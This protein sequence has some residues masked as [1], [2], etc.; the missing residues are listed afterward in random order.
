MVVS[1]SSQFLISELGVN[2]FKQR[3]PYLISVLLH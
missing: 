3:E 2:F 1:H